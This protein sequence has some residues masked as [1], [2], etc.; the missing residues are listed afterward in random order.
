MA[1][2]AALQVKQQT[3]ENA[4]ENFLPIY[5]YLRHFLAI[6]KFTEIPIA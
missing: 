4:F 3:Q 5:V 2:Y 1:S 6:N